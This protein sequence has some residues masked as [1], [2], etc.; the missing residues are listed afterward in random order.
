MLAEETEKDRAE[1]NDC[2]DGDCLRNGRAV[3]F[4]VI[5]GGKKW[6]EKEEEGGVVCERKRRLRGPIMVGQR[7]R[8]R[9]GAGTGAGLAPGSNRSGIRN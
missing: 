9:A 1:R 4:V 8:V 6:E 5:V 7:V 2:A 3:V